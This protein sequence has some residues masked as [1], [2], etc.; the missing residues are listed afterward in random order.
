[1][2]EK[3]RH[4]ITPSLPWLPVL[5]LTACIL[6]ADRITKAA[7]VARLV[8]G[9]SIPVVPGVLHLTLVLNTGGA[10]GL[11]KDGR[12]FFIPFSLAAIACIIYYLIRYRPAGGVM[13]AAF[14]LIMGGAIGNLIDRLRYGYVIDFLDLRVWPVFNLADSAITAGAGLLII[15]VMARDRVRTSRG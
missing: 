11:F 10:F 14:G 8:E 15:A 12:L 13:A 4:D 1:M 6:A 5:A 3:E 7:A 2:P 9:Q